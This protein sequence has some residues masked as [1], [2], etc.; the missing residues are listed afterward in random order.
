[1]Y[2]F[3]CLGGAEI[4]FAAWAAVLSFVWRECVFCWLGRAG[5]RVLFFAVWA[6]TFLCFLDTRATS[7][8][9]QRSITRPRSDSKKTS[10][11]APPPDLLYTPPTRELDCESSVWCQISMQDFNFL[12]KSQDVPCQ[13]LFL[14]ANAREK[15][16]VIA[17]F[18]RAL[19]TRKKKEHVKTL[20]A[21][22]QL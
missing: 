22:A 5:V 4:C 7:L 3:C 12:A 20:H 9:K 2:L 6:G 13:R 10:P 15:K 16:H 14:Y 21:K 11:A 19:H 17:H 18:A 1:M 8:P